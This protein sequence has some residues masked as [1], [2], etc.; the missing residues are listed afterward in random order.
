MS[1]DNLHLRLHRIEKNY[2][3]PFTISDLPLLLSRHHKRKVKR[4]LQGINLEIG[5]GERVGIIGQN[6]AGKSTL[7]KIIAGTAMP[8]GGELDVNGKV[9]AVLTLGVGLREEYSGRENLY[10]EAEA[11]GRSRSEIE[12]LIADMIEFAGLGEFIDKPVKTYSSGMK[13]RLVFSSLVF[14]EPEIL[15]LDETLATGDQWFQ[16]KARHA[17]HKLCERG[18]IVIVVSHSMASII[19]ICSRC[20]WIRDGMIAEDGD[21]REVVRKYEEYQRMRINAKVDVPVSRQVRVTNPASVLIESMQFRQN[22]VELVSGTVISGSALSIEADL[23]GL[24]GCRL[25]QIAMRLTRA[26]GLLLLHSDSSLELQ[27]E[28]PSVSSVTCTVEAFD[29]GPGRYEC[30]LTVTDEDT[31]VAEASL[32]IW[33]QA[34][35]LPKGGTPLF[36]SGISMEPLP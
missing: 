3:E 6:G 32:P 34:Q 5:E 7:L 13:S 21:P 30:T 19:D 16:A 35:K 29:L 10:L 31:V 18:K 24:A 22:G 8:S 33:V 11:L 1:T 28:D 14:V 36:L 26:D 9:H 4:V 25:P 2:P 20:I 17:I 23:R 12:P 27:G 15:M